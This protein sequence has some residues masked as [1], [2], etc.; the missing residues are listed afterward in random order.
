M[1]FQFLHL[2]NTVPV[3]TST[4]SLNGI[5][6]TPMHQGFIRSE[7]TCADEKSYCRGKRHL[8]LF[9]INIKC[10]N[11]SEPYHISECHISCDFNARQQR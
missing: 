7:D 2:L 3:W 5:K 4:F 11:Y 1:H 8:Y 10:L 6:K 9:E